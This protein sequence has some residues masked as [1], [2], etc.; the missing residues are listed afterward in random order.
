MEPDR[1]DDVAYRI[2]ESPE[3]PRRRW[4]KRWTVVA[5]ASVLAAGGLAA[6]ASALTGSDGPG[7]NA[8]A[9]PTKATGVTGD[10]VATGRDGR[11]C[12]GGK[13]G[14]DGRHRQRGSAAAFNY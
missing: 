4:R 10:G 7:G 3:P 2:V 8:T 13:A 5:A 9:K 11:W 14:K 1:V 6:G 12:R